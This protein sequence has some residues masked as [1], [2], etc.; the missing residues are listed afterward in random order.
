[1]EIA[2]TGIAEIG[3][4]RSSGRSNGSPLTTGG[5]PA[6]APKTANGARGKRPKVLGIDASKFLVSVCA[7]PPIRKAHC[8][9]AAVYRMHPQEC[10]RPV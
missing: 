10:S 6:K 7:L 3:I 9:L 2:E 5:K 1:M 8:K 4:A